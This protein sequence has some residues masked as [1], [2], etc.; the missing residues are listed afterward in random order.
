MILKCLATGSKANCYV[1]KRDNGEMLILDAGLPIN[2]IK[3]G[4]EF[5]VTNLKG[6][7]ITHGH[8]DHVLSAEKLK[9][10]TPVWKPYENEHK[11]LHTHLGDFD[12]TSFDV[13]HNGVE[14]RG[15]LIGVDE[16]M[17]LYVTD[18]EY[19]PYNLASKNIDT[20]LIEL[21][22]QAENIEDNP[23]NHM[24]HVILGHAE[25]KVTIEILRQNTKSLRSVILCHMSNSGNLNRELAMKNIK[26]VLPNYVQ[27][28]WAKAGQTYNISRVPF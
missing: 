16:Q 3:K 18:F 5:D 8:G 15:F 14:N 28:S 24:S 26:D 13:P 6:A 4:I 19:I 23:N 11:K 7:L 21:N 12:I 17:I 9:Q 10:F 22:Y 2:E 25:E 1:L 27:V 20:M